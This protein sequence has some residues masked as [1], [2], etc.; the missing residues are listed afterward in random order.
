M[1]KLQHLIAFTLIFIFILPIAVLA[2]EKP[3]VKIETSMG[4]IILEL[5]PEKA[6]ANVKNFLQYVNGAYYDGL[7]FHRVIKGF[8]IQTGGYDADGKSR[9]ALKPVINES[10]HGLKNKKWTVA[11]ARSDDADSATTQFYIN[12]RNNKNL[13]ATRKKKGYTVFGRVVEGI[14]VVKAIEKVEVGP[15][16]YLG[17]HR[18][19]DDVFV[20]K[21]RVIK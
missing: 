6:P 21:A 18:P 20:I 12:T 16:L 17:K 8:M 19:V 10:L 4:N 5:D 9:P 1:K 7:I 3:R 14:N 2:A 11:M 13:D 15:D